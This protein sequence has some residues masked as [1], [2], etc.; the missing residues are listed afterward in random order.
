MI[1]PE[2]QL[3]RIDYGDRIYFNSVTG[4]AGVIYPIGTA[5]MP[6]SVIADII[7]MCT[8]LNLNT[9]QVHGAL[10][11]GDTMEHYSFVGYEHEDFADLIDLNEKDVDSSGFKQLVITGTQGGTGYAFF[12]DCTLVNVVSLRGVLHRCILNGT[13][14]LATGGVDNI[15]FH[16]CAAR[17]GTATITVNAPDLVNF[18]DFEGELILATMTGGVVNIFSSVGT[19]ITIN[20]SCTAG[21]INIYGDAHIVNNSG[22]T[23]V[24]DYT[25]NMAAAVD[26]AVVTQM[27]DVIGNKADTPV[28]ARDVSASSMRYLM[29]LVQ[30]GIAIQ[31]TVN[32]VAPA[33]AQF[34]TDLTEATDD[35]YN[36]MLLMFLDGPNAGQA[37]VINDYDGAGKNVSF[38]A[39]DIW[40]DVPGNGNS[41]VILPSVGNM[42]KAIYASQGRQLFSMDFWSLPQEEVALTIAAADKG[43]PSV[44]VAD[45]PGAATI[46]RAIA[47]FKFRM[48]ENHTYAGVNSLDG[49]QE[50]QVAASV[51][52]I[53]FVTGQ[54]TLAQD[55]REGGDVV[56]GIIDIAATVNANGAY[57]FHWDLAKALQTGINF[58]DIQMGIRIWYSV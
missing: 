30:A 14:A 46:V 51:D 47:M 48:V 1:D 6:S 5:A 3:R 27:R 35:H 12:N 28:F 52:A 58:N 50:I 2:G 13:N 18:F 31:S 33:A 40:T 21:T 34:D 8:A 38:S 55:T 37:H 26:S 56:I 36:G 44:T 57:A 45:L 17:Q 19:E 49:A 29:G 11:L 16:K 53:N 10:T 7:T 41:F 9:I 42:A 23:V 54:F 32:D 43:L 20:V 22:G 4:I 15:D 24:N 25:S 39:E